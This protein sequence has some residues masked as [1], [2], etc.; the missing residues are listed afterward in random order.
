VNIKLSNEAN[1][2]MNNLLN[3]IA[4][5]NDVNRSIRRKLAALAKK[6][7]PDQD[8]VNLKKDEITGVNKLLVMIDTEVCAPAI[9]TED[10]K[11]KTLALKTQEVVNAIRTK[12]DAA[13]ESNPRQS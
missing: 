12:L 11:R 5:G 7:N 4:E 2:Y 9:D 3:K 13:I 6:F 8:S 1:I 10:E